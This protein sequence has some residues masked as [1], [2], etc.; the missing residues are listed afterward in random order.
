MN[1]IDLTDMAA[2]EPISGHSQTDTNTDS[3]HALKEE[4][5][6]LQ[7]ELRNAANIYDYLHKRFDGVGKQIMGIGVSIKVLEG[8]RDTQKAALVGLEKL[9]HDYRMRF[10]ETYNCKCGARI[11][12]AQTRCNRCGAVQ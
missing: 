3:I 4:L 12:E 7:Q 5:E 8:D 2:R 10:P 9:R 1:E 6:N 11:A